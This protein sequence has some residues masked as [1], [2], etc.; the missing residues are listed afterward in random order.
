MQMAPGGSSPP[1]CCCCYATCRHGTGLSA[2]VIAMLL[3]HS[4][5]HLP[6]LEMTSWPGF[7]Q[8]VYSAFKN[9]FSF[10]KGHAQKCVR[11]GG[12]VALSAARTPDEYI[13]KKKK[14][15]LVTSEVPERWD[16]HLLNH[17]LL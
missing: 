11:G 15:G 10:S 14:R 13:R 6:W 1:C 3:G 7:L 5:Q 4:L 2:P 12:G 17:C 16:R 9:V 8:R